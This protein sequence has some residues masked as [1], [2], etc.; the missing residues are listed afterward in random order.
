MFGSLELFVIS[1]NMINI[2]R[3]MKYN[4][5][6]IHKMPKCP[7]WQMKYLSLGGAV[8][9]LLSGTDKVKMSLG[10]VDMPPLGGTDIH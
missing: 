1:L 8:V 3:C 10:G 7:N 5:I 9:L 2:D 4:N 6:C